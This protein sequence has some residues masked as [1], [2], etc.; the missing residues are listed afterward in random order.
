MTDWR[1]PLT[2]I[3]VPEQDVR[4]VLFA[5][6]DLT[7]LSQFATTVQLPTGVSLTVVD[8]QGTILARVPDAGG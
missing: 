8:H 4:A 6:L 1:M 3:S 5:A 2:D 7:W